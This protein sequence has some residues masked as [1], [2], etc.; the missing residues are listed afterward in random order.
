[1]TN[2]LYVQKLNDD[3]LSVMGIDMSLQGSNLFI[4]T[5]RQYGYTQQSDE[6]LNLPSPG[7]YGSLSGVFVEFNTDEECKSFSPLSDTFR[8]F[9][10]GVSVQGKTYVPN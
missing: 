8:P 9:S 1:M 5:L 2:K 3:R 4:E 10:S 6:V 7:K